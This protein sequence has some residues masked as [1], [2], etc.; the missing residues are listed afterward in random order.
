MVTNAAIPLFGNVYN[1][2]SPDEYALG[3]FQVSAY[4]SKTVFINE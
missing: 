3:Y 2:N 4:V 1:A